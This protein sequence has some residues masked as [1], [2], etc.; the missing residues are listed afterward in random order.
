MIQKEEVHEKMELQHDHLVKL[1][2]MICR[3]LE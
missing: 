1:L 3:N 2:A